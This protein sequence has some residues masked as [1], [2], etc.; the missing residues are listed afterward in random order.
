M[1]SS[2]GSAVYRLRL[3][4]DDVAPTVW[5]RVLVPG[6][7]TLAALHKMIQA[8]M[9]WENLHLHNFVI[10]DKMYGT[11]VDDYPE[12]ELDET[13]VTVTQA[14]GDRRRFR[15]E[16]DFGDAW[17]HDVVVEDLT[18][19]SLDLR[20]AVC[21]D[22]QNA[23]PPEDCGG[24]PGYE[25][26]LEV[27]GDPAHEEHERMARW[28]GREVDPTAFDLAGANAALQRVR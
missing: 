18:P 19:V 15:Y 14:V 10:D 7:A 3:T 6:S 20:F 23:C 8:A 16:Y 12:D 9:G 27:L 5:R 26:L 11:Q 4:L 21:I 28:V 22:G 24:S 2:S 17:G 1:P 13:A 25:E